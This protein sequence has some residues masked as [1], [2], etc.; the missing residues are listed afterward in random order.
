[1]QP[2]TLY[3]ATD[4]SR[5]TTPEA[6][7]KR[8]VF[9]EA[10]RLAMEPLG[11]ARP[12][13]NGAWI[14]HCAATVTRVKVAVLTIAERER[15]IDLNGKPPASA[16]LQ[17]ILGRFFDDAGSNPAS[18]AWHRLRC[19]VEEAGREYDQPYF[20]IHPEQANRSAADRCESDGATA[21]HSVPATS[22]RATSGR[23]G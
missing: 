10:I 6:A 9:C 3:E 17:G 18:Q 14:Q 8:D 2:I 1:M 7:T 23:A 11:P 19:I 16:H 15:V 12:L 4:G 22:A 5:W 21:R 20:A 13:R